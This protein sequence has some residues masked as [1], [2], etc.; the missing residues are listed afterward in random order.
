MTVTVTNNLTQIDGAESATAYQSNAPLAVTGFQ[1]EGTNCIGDQAS[2]DWEEMYIN[3]I[4]GVDYTNRTI[5]IWMRSGNPPTEANNGLGVILGSDSEVN[6]VAYTVG[7]SDNYGHFVLGWSSFRL[8]TANLPSGNRVLAGSPPTLTAITDIGASCGMNSKAAGNA[9][10]VFVDEFRWIANGAAALTIIGGT[11]GARGTFAEMVTEDIDIT[12]GKAFGIIRE[13]VGA[14]AYELFFGVEWGAA[15]GDTFFEDSG[16]QLFINGNG[17]GDA[18]MTAGNMDVDLIA[19]T[20]TNLFSLSDGVIVGIG[21][22]SNWDLSAAMNTFQFNRMVV[23]DLGTILFPIAGGTLRECLNSTFNNCGQLYLNTMT[24]FGL[25]FNGTTDANGV[26]LWDEDSDEEAQDALT[27]NSDGTGHA[28]EIA[29]VGAGPFVFNVDTYIFDGYAGQ[30]GT[31]GD[32]VFLIDPDNGDADTI[33]INLADSSALNVQGGGEG[34]SYELGG[35]VT[36]TPSIISTVTLTVNVAD[37]ATDPLEDVLVS[38]RAAS[39]NSLISQGRTDASG[40]Y[41]DGSYNF[42]GE[43]AVIINVRKSSPGDTRYFPKSDPAT[44]IATGLSATVAMIEDTNAGLIDST[45]FDIAKHGQVS[46]DVD[47]AVITAKVKLPGGSG[48]KLVVG[49]G[50]WDSTANRAVTSLLYDGNA[51]TVITSDFVQEG[52]EF[53][54]IFLYRYDIPD[55]DSGTKDV[56]L[57]LDGTA[58]FRFLAFAVINLAATGAEEDSDVSSGQAVTSNPS[59]SLNN[60]TQPAIDVMFSVTDDLDTFPPAATGEGSIRRADEMVDALKQ[61]TIIRADRT[62]TGAHNVGADYDASS[63]SYVSAGA[64]FAD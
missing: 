64:T 58:P 16:F 55:T 47:G 63:K 18:G 11:T 52:S 34:F 37:A 22:R 54:E 1:R 30:S 49:C 48:R 6:L 57:T 23:T 4:G 53:H 44:I 25:V 9:D 14:K 2:N 20:G 27:F 40:V 41:T 35:G 26:I 5:F 24:M 62:S 21:T 61:I 28:I 13:L 51:M 29:P 38:I 17:S 10:N 15:T 3:T 8:D 7:G 59:L 60:T 36:G 19:G 42:G 31:A 56:V 12:A 39:D 50:Y 33:T 43:V 46:N 45:R 32:R